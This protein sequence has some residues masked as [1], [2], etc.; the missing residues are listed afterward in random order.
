[1]D[2]QE[3]LEK[4]ATQVKAMRAQGYVSKWPEEIRQEALFLAQE[5]GFS[6]VALATKLQVIS[7]H[8]WEKSTQEKK[9]LSLIPPQR[10][11]ELQITRFV[12]RPQEIPLERK[13]NIIATVSKGEVELK[14]FCKETVI[15]FA[16]RV[17]S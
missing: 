2:E 17:F 4:L 12:V 11:D 3:R 9:S 1:M 15:E 7:L 10:R 5:F 13:N 8:Q 6:K 14:F 16:Q